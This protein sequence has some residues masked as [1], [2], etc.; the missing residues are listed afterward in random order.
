MLAGAVNRFKT[1][2]GS[3]IQISARLED[4]DATAAAWRVTGRIQN[5]DEIPPLVEDLAYQIVWELSGDIRTKSWTAFK[6]VSQG[7]LDFQKWNATNAADQFTASESEFQAA[8]KDDPT[9]VSARYY[10]GYLYYMADYYFWDR[11]QGRLLRSSITDD[12]GKRAME[13]FSAIERLVQIWG[14]ESDEAYAHLGRG[15]M[16]GDRYWD[17]VR[18]PGRAQA[19]VDKRFKDAEDELRKAAEID[20]TLIL[21]RLALGTLFEERAKHVPEDEMKSSLESA[22]SEFM[23]AAHVEGADDAA[24]NDSIER[25][26]KLRAKLRQV[27]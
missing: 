15:V 19:D 13:Q 16:N 2:D 12:D 25:A 6:H 14:R 9:Y 22:V 11:D 1:A 4:G 3:L 17:L 7:L 21:P 20:A 8:V 24:R 23:L 27:R 10:L 26:D 5:D 18:Q